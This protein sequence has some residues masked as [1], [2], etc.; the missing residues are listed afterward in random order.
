[1]DLPFPTDVT[2]FDADDRISFSKL[3]GKFLAVLDDGAEFEFD[4]DQKRWVPAE[5]NT[6]DDDDAEDYGGA[7]RAGQPEEAELGSKKRK[8]G[9]AETTQGDNPKPS[10]PN[11]RQKPPPQPRQNTA[12]YVT[13][14][15]SDATVDEVYDVFSRKG[16]VIAEE[17]DSGAPRIKLYKDEEGNFKGDALIVFFKPQSVEMAIM[18][19]D[20]TDFRITAT[21]AAEGRMRVQAADTSYK[22]VQHDQEGGGGGGQGAAAAGKQGGEKRPPQRNDRDRQKIIKRTQKLDAKLAD[23]DDDEPYSARGETAKVSSKWDKVVILSHMFTLQ[24]LEED[25]AALLEIKEDIRD[26][27][28]KLGTVT[29]VVLFDLESEGI[30]SVKFKD[31]ASAEACI[32]VMR[33]RS[34]GGHTVNAFLAT[35]R[36]KF[37]KSSKA[38]AEEEDSD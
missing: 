10:R 34:F 7:P 22:K 18:L 1:M 26:E 33:G 6:L 21:G 14:L 12:I 25:P 4:H 32:K 23:W 15:P 17:I 16:G 30:V 3:D 36:E 24:E 35:G 38:E 2:E 27:C 8:N 20:D 9:A 31:A 37:Q 13:G 28:S 29:N 19:L 11:K 5:Y